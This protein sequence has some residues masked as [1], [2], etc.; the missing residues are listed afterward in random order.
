MSSVITSK[1]AAQDL[2]NIKARH[3]DIITGMTN[4]KI[5]VDQ[6]NQQK[7]EQKAAE[8]QNKKIMD[9]EMKQAAMTNKTMADKNAMDFHTKNAELDIQRAALSKP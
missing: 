6:Y 7:Q 3:A 2:L 5:K 8:M 1:K 4:Q 9:N